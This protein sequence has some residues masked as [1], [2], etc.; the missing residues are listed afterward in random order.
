MRP[1]FL[2]FALACA[3]GSQVWNGTIP[4]LAAKPTKIKINAKVNSLGDI[5]PSICISVSQFS[6][7]APGWQLPPEQKSK[8]IN[9]N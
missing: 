3:C 2:M 8:S 5:D 7:P 9:A 4:D 1:L 6:V